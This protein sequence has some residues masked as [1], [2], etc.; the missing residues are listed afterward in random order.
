MTKTIL[1]TGCSSG[2][3]RMTAKFFQEKGW[4]VIATVRDKPEEDTELNALDNVLVTALDVTKLDTIEAA[5]AAGIERFGAIDVLLNNAGYGAYGILEA[6]PEHKIRM[7]FDVNVIGP[8][9][10]TKVV[11]PHMRARGEGTIINISSMGGKVTFP[12]GTLYHGSKFAVEGMSEALSFE[13]A[14]IGVKVKMIEPGMINTNF[15]ETTGSLLDIDPS[16]EDYTPFLE[17]VLAG[18]QQAGSQHSE[19]IIVAEAVWKAATDGTDQMRYI[20]GPDAEQL[21]SARKAMED[22]EYLAM[23][24]SNMGL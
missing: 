23:V 12:L 19:P 4:N 8:L 24:R 10:C 3:G 2:I 13:L 20:A 9:L 16:Q 22:P 18:M 15:A 14:A 7:Q 11:L 21:I 6:T 17:K 1:I 5:M